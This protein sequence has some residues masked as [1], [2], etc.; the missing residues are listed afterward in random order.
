MQGEVGGRTYPPIGWWAVVLVL[1]ITVG[2]FVIVASDTTQTYH[3]AIT[4]FQGAA[5]AILSIVIQNILLVDSGAWQAAAAGFIL[6][7]IIM[8]SALV[9]SPPRSR[10]HQ[11]NA[12]LS[13]LGLRR[14]ASS[15][16]LIS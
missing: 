3:V 9:S 6:L 8:V 14:F 7:A 13:L 16:E 5:L 1:L 4:V 12:Q 11:T 2:V 10:H 15:E